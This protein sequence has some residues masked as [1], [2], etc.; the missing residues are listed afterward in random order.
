MVKFNEDQNNQSNSTWLIL[1][2]LL[3]QRQLNQY[4]SFHSAISLKTSPAGIKIKQVKEISEE[5]LKP[6]IDQW[7]R[8]KLP[9]DLKWLIW[10][11]HDNYYC[12]PFLWAFLFGVL[13]SFYFPSNLFRDG[14]GK[15]FCLCF[16]IVPQNS[17]DQY[18]VNFIDTLKMLVWNF[19]I[20]CFPTHVSN[21]IPLVPT[22]SR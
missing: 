12:Y 15:A 19:L 18:L 4:L 9:K 10:I 2:F 1:A 22:Y 6:G 21:E 13:F 17:R 8:I 20:S 7:I 14:L 5:K 3:G 16:I 11:I